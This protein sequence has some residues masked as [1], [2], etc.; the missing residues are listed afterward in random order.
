MARF[1]A[2]RAKRAA[3]SVSTRNWE[4]FGGGPLKLNRNYFV[5]KG[6]N[7]RYLLAELLNFP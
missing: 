7:R 6:K 3:G 1:T 4:T 5:P 2:S